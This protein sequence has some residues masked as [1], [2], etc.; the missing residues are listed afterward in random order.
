MIQSIIKTT[1]TVLI[2]ILSTLLGTSALAANVSDG[3]INLGASDFTWNTDVGPNSKWETHGHNNNQEYGDGS[4]GERYDLNFLGIDTAGDQFQF[5]VGG[6][7]ILSSPHMGREVK[8]SS[9]YLGDI[10]ISVQD[11]GAA[12]EDP[13]VNST[14]SS[15]WQYALRILGVDKPNNEFAFQVVSGGSWEA[16]DIYGREAA[17]DGHHSDTFRMNN[18]TPESKVLTGKYSALEKDGPRND[19][20]VLEGSFDLGLLSLFNEHT[21][22]RIITYLTMS[23]TNDE[24]IVYADIAAVP[25]PAAFWLFG[26]ALLGFIGISRRT[27]V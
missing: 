24:A 2:F 10:A 7:S 26:T 18:A 8:T 15:A 5:G 4:G 13:T 25:V 11:F 23:C 1:T 22:G 20:Y 19:E 17:G 9:L 14:D 3:I 16:V 12:Y 21:G 27:A 6:G